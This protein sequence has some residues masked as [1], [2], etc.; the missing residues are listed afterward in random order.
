VTLQLSPRPEVYDQVQIERPDQFQVFARKPVQ[1]GS[2]V[3]PALRE[4]LTVSSAEAAE[5]A[6]VE[7]IGDW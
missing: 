3:E 1:P 6:K 7:V 4:H 5:I 2:P